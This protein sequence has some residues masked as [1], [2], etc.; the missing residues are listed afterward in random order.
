MSRVFFSVGGHAFSSGL[1]ASLFPVPLLELVDSHPKELASLTSSKRV[2]SKY[3]W[4]YFC[5]SPP[6]LIFVTDNPP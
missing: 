4:E 6:L 1:S 3:G 2:N 5:F